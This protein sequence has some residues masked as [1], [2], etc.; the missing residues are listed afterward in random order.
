VAA[1]V[2][3]LVVAGLGGC[4]SPQ[5]AATTT[6][7]S[8]TS[9]A[10]STSTTTTSATPVCSAPD[11]AVSVSGTQGA[12]GTIEVTFALRNAGASACSLSG[13]PGVVL[14]AGSGANLPTTVVRAGS[15]SFTDF[16]PASV[17]L[18][19]GAA[20]YVN[21]AYSDVV[22]GTETVCPASTHVLFM[23]PGAGGA[24]AVSVQMVACDGGTVTVS[25]VLGAGSP[26]T[27]TTAP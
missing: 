2:G 17:T 7:T 23:A 6:T 12:A 10:S 8:S 20:G 27:A 14:V 19:P 13:F 5:Q 22:T 25:P 9:T 11:L 15:Y 16:A 18:A 24:D 26:A 1:G 4:S 21:L 3:A